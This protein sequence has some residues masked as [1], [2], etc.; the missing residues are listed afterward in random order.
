MRINYNPKDLKS[1]DKVGL[2]RTSNGYT[3]V[4]NIKVDSKRQESL[5]LLISGTKGD[6][7]I[8][9]KNCEFVDVTPH[10][11]KDFILYQDSESCNTSIY[12][13]GSGTIFGGSYSY[14]P[15]NI[16][17]KHIPGGIEYSTKEDK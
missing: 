11:G 7:K 14:M 16:D 17:I 1:S 9:V 4:E 10:E 12:K 2:I 5:P 3:A 6:D 8:V 15:K 13:G